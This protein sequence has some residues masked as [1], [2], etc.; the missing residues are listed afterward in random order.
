[1]GLLRLDV[2]L[3][4]GALKENLSQLKVIHDIIHQTSKIIDVLNRYDACLTDIGRNVLADTECT[5]YSLLRPFE[6]C[7]TNE[8]YYIGEDDPKFHS[9]NEP[10]LHE[11]PL[12]IAFR[13]KPL[14]GLYKGELSGVL[15]VKDYKNGKEVVAKFAVYQGIERDAHHWLSAESRH[16]NHMARLRKKCSGEDCKYYD[17]ILSLQ[18]DFWFLGTKYL[19]MP[20]Y[21]HSL[22]VEAAK[23]WGMTLQHLKLRMKQILMGVKA[24]K[25]A[26]IIHLDLKPENILVNGNQLVIADLGFAARVEYLTREKNSM[27][28]TRVFVSPEVET[29]LYH[30]TFASDMFS[31]GC[32]FADMVTDTDFETKLAKLYKIRNHPQPL[33]SA[34]AWRLFNSEKRAL[35]RSIIYKSAIER[36]EYDPEIPQL[37]EFI[38]LFL[39]YNPH[40]RLTVEQALQHRFLKDVH[41]GFEMAADDNINATI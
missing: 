24:L 18:D 32:V 28:G 19:I 37:C 8:I 9:V 33:G 41:L 35:L 34:I 31:V 26:N 23:S 10:V 40:N 17:Y 25:M 20:K 5:P 14:K 16:L 7:S 12:H 13:Y 38:T 1:M 6:Q 21:E 27:R 39:A 30:A 11:D 3:I 36:W 4:G 29:G 22:D 2:T 15:S